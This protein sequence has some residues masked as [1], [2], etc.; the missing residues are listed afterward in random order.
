MLKK[1]R[2][3]F[4]FASLMLI[5]LVF[6]SPLV[7]FATDPLSGDQGYSGISWATG[8]NTIV[9]VIDEGVWQ[10]HPDLRDAVWVNNKEI[11][12]NGIDDDQNSYI[13][14]YYGWNFLDNN[15]DMDPKGNHGTMVAGII[16]AQRNDVGVVGIAPGSKIMSLIACSDIGCSSKG[17]RNAIKYA[18]DNGADVIN[19]SLGSSGYVGYSAEYDYYVKYA[20]DRGVVVVA[21]A[22]NGDTNSANQLGQDLNFI[23]VSPASNDV[24]GVN[25]VVGVGATKHS[26]SE[27]TSWSNYGDKFVDVWAPGEEIISTTVPSF[28]KSYGY[29]SG[30]GTSFA[31]PMVSAAAALIISE[32]PKFT[33]YEIIDTLKVNTPLN[34]S[35]LL[36][37]S[38]YQ[39]VCSIGTFNKEVI[40]GEIFKIDASHLKPNLAFTLQ[41]NINKNITSIPNEAITILDATKLLIDTSKI[42]IS[43]GTYTLNATNC[44]VQWNTL[45]IK[46]VPRSTIVSEPT[47]VSA[48]APKENTNTAVV[49]KK[50][51]KEKILPAPAVPLDA[52]DKPDIMRQIFTYRDQNFSL[53]A[54]QEILKKKV[55]ISPKVAE[56]EKIE[57]LNLPIDVA[58]AKLKYSSAVN[59][60]LLDVN[61]R[62]LPYYVISIKQPVKFLGLFKGVFN[63]EVY[64][65]A[66]DANSKTRGEKKFFD[67]MFKI[68]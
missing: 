9:A 6:T 28:S 1:L 64:I 33:V 22:G 56:L 25:M 53:T 62:N 24:E 47:I 52:K 32:N 54:D 4:T 68:I 20:Y 46:G 39:R 60:V 61:D 36:N 13:D 27:K 63:R 26:S 67:F 30:D 51:E 3:T 40:N 16:A 5:A 37:Q 41:N 12:Q 10:E 29:K 35:I 43:E 15:S 11:P 66:S 7:V 8:K 58:V 55:S 17:V 2:P 45:A 34:V 21:S 38:V 59:S 31:A 50:Q 57:S 23:K 48:E 14:D 44:P 49:N 65:D 42:N 19:L 18:V